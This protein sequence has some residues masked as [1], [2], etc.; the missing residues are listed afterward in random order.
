MG[1]SEKSSH[2]LSLLRKSPFSGPLGDDFEVRKPPSPGRWP[3]TSV[4]A[5]PSGTV[6]A[7]CAGILNTPVSNLADWLGPLS[8]RGPGLMTS[9]A[10]SAPV[11]PELRAGVPAFLLH[12][13]T[14]HEMSASADGTSRPPFPPL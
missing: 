3:S 6:I 8:V 4:R 13:C 7:G 10:R 2:Q 9:P 12:H 1:P 5:S 14:V 11:T